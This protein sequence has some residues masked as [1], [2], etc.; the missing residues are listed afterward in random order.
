MFDL[1]LSIRETDDSKPRPSHAEL[2]GAGNKEDAM[3][4]SM[5]EEEAHSE[6][7]GSKRTR[8]SDSE[9]DLPSTPESV[10]RMRM[11]IDQETE[12][13]P[14]STSDSL[15]NPFSS[16]SHITPL[17]LPPSLVEARDELKQEWGGVCKNAG[18]LREEGGV[19]EWIRKLHCNE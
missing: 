10:K 9:G 1:D 6:S 5:Y 4:N 17:R 14:I 11:L 7:S 13:Q 3:M 15:A 19:K 16:A 18:V 2:A 8:F 12:T